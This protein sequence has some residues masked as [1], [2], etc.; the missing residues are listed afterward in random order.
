MHEK[1]YY[2]KVIGKN[3]YKYRNFADLTQEKIAD[4]LDSSN[5]CISRI[6][7]PKSKETFSLAMIGRISDYIGIPIWYLFDEEDVVRELSNK[8]KIIHTED[9]F[10]ELFRLNLRRYRKAL[11]VTQD[12][13]AKRTSL[14]KSTIGRI[15]SPKIKS[16]FTIFTIGK[17]ADALGVSVV[18]LFNDDNLNIDN[19]F[20]RK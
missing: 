20:K 9:Y 6:E 2:Y 14:D 8:E 3:L 10:Y 7:N 12:E 4:A 5:E 19:E 15:E 18:K 17:I 11:G 1:D 13:L 16:H